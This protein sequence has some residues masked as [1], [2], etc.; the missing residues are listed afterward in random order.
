MSV[1]E[2]I[3]RE[4]KGAFGFTDDRRCLFTYGDFR[5]LLMEIEEAMK[6]EIVS[7]RSIKIPI[8]IMPQC[9]A[10]ATRE[11]FKKLDKELQFCEKNVNLG[12]GFSWEG[13][14]EHCQ[15]VREILNDALSLPPRNCDRF[16]NEREMQFAFLAERMSMG[17]NSASLEEYSK[18]LLEKSKGGKE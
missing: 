13:L 9:N 1:D 2:I 12:L 11:A 18:W 5:R 4:R 3:E 6:R 14:R 10:A 16:N 15:I 17:I 8:E 7:R